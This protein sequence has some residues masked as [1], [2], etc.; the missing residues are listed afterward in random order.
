[1][2]IVVVCWFVL[3]IGVG[4]GAGG[5]RRSGL[6]WFMLALIL[7]PLFAGLLLPILPDLRTH[8]LPKE[9]A[10]ANASSIDDRELMRN[11]KRGAG[12]HP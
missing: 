5:R 2:I 4:I 6:R 8:E 11:A 9:I 12:W 3:A 10:D 1:M 7:S